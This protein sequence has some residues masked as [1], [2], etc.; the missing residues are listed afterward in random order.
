MLTA[1]FRIVGPFQK[2][3]KSQPNP[4][5]VPETVSHLRPACVL[6]VTCS[7]SSLIRDFIFISAVNQSNPGN[8]LFISFRKQS[9][10]HVTVIARTLYWSTHVFRRVS[11]HLSIL[12]ICKWRGQDLKIGILLETTNLWMFYNSVINLDMHAKSGSCPWT[13]LSFYKCTNDRMV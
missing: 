7:M 4:A 6:S 3:W 1:C 12:I 2:K 11:P 8:S 10:L 9:G 5:C 13:P